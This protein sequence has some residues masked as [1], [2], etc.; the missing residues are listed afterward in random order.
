MGIGAP[1]HGGT[2][3]FSHMTLRKHR[4]VSLS[5]HE[6]SAWNGNVVLYAAVP[7]TARLPLLQCVTNEFQIP[8]RVRGRKKV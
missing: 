7:L 3:R 2:S 4:V 1:L 5:P 8:H 6:T